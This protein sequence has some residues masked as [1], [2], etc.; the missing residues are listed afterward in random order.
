MADLDLWINK[1]FLS[2][3]ADDTQTCVI[4]DSPEELKEIVEEE[5]RAV[6]K[7]F[8]GINLCNNADKAALLVNSKGFAGNMSIDIGGNILRCTSCGKNF[9]HQQEL[10]EH[11]GTHNCEGLLAYRDH[12]DDLPR[13]YHSSPPPPPAAALVNQPP[14]PIVVH[15]APEDPFLF[16]FFFGSRYSCFDVDSFSF[17]PHE[18]F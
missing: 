15:Q 18:L 12:D 8:S 10:K 4:A 7:F 3:Y 9:Y 16:H 11:E 6:L 2:N 13:W 1:S 5:S 14:G 17:S